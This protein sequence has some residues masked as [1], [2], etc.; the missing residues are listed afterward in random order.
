VLVDRAPHHESTPAD[1]GSVV[2][3]PTWPYWPDTA[4]RLD[5]T[6]VVLRS[7]RG[8]RPG[9]DLFHLAAE[10]SP[11]TGGHADP[12]LPCEHERRGLP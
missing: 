10:E 11:L 9:Q 6:D 12:S 7:L 4:D 5:G 3:G 8:V 2:V 1:P